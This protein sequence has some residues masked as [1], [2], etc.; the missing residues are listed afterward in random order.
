M[1]NNIYLAINMDETKGTK[2]LP[3][4]V[5]DNVAILLSEN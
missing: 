2:V 3:Q 1:R 5:Y 4:E